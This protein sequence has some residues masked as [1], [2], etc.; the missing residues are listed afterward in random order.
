MGPGFDVCNLLEEPVAHSPTGQEDAAHLVFTGEKPDLLNLCVLGC[1]VFV[2]VPKVSKLAPH[3]RVGHWMGFDKESKTHRIYW[4]NHR[5]PVT[6]KCSVH[7]FVP[8]ELRT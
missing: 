2:H 6:V 1:K 5:H 7:N 3:A 4:S 8:E